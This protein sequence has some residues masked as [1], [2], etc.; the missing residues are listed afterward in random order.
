MAV[1]TRAWIVPGLR[2]AAAIASALCCGAL[3]AS[4]A[5]AQSAS[6][7]EVKAAFVYNFA[8]FSEWPPDALPE[9]MP[10]LLCVT[11]DD[12][13]EG[14]LRKAVQGQ[15]IGG[16]PLAVRHVD[17]DAS[18]RHCHVVYGSRLDLGHVRQ[19]LDL[20][21]DAPVLSVSDVGSFANQGGVAELYKEGDK[22]RFAVN[23]E[24]AQR[25]HLR[26]SS[27]LLSLAR[28]VKDERDVVRR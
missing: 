16:R 6:A 5:R 2:V 1:L 4:R 14:A 13:L 27:K 24:S 15:T 7:S 9:Q 28:I 17:L 12:E 23:L 21:K 10:L 26:L 3:T 11:G 18:M 22:M 8:K 19:L 20:I 25:A